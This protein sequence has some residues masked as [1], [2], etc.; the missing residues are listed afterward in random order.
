MPMAGLP[1]D[2]VGWEGALATGDFVY[3]MDSVVV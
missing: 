3:G 1:A 2:L